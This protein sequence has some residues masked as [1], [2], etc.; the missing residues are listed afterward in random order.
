LI[1]DMIDGNTDILRIQNRDG[2]WSNADDGTLIYSMVPPTGEFEMTSIVDSKGAR[3]VASQEGS[4]YVDWGWMFGFKFHWNGSDYDAGAYQ[5]IRFS[6]VSPTTPAGGSIDVR[7]EITNAELEVSCG[8]SCYAYYGKT[9]QLTSEWQNIDVLWAE[10][11]P[12]RAITAPFNPRHVRVVW[13]IFPS[14][15]DALIEIDSVRFIP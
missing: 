7:V 8:S 12:R 6:I 13:V 11:T 15:D 4:L 3:W 14:G 1:D 2:Y 9:I 10:L 5:G